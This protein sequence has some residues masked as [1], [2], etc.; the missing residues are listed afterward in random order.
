[1]KRSATCFQ[2]E[3]LRLLVFLIHE[4]I[5][6]LRKMERRRYIPSSLLTASYFKRYAEPWK[7]IKVTSFGGLFLN[8]SANAGTFD[9]IVRKLFPF[10]PSITSLVVHSSRLFKRMSI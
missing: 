9:S 2:H 6:N 5:N 7:G 4:M 10:F 1:M 8:E 3:F